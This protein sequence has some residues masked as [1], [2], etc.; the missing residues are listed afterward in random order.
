MHQSL[1]FDLFTLFY[2]R[3]TNVNTCN[4]RVSKHHSN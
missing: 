3:E 1:Q 4:G 2:Y